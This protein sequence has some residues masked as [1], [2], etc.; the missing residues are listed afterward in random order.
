MAPAMKRILLSLTFALV[1]GLSLAACGSNNCDKLA[2]EVSACFS[3]LDC[4][5]RAEG[6]ERMACESAKT[7][8]DNATGEEGECTEAIDALAAACLGKVSAD[9]NCACVVN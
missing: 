3:D 8:H 1:A 7:A 4:S 2:D 9:D 6:A 5:T